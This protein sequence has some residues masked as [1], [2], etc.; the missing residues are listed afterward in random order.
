MLLSCILQ[1]VVELPIA[2][3]DPLDFG[4]VDAGVVPVD[5]LEI[6]AFQNLVNLCICSF[7]LEELLRVEDDQG[8]SK[9]PVHLPSQDVE[10]VGAGGAR[11]N[12]DVGLF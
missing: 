6:S 5:R 7:E 9:L 4:G 11:Y 3:I 12:I 1:V 10:I 8:F 2:K